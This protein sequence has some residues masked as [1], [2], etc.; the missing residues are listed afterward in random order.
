MENKY[1]ATHPEASSRNIIKNVNLCQDETKPDKNGKCT[2]CIAITIH[3]SSYTHERVTGINLWLTIQP[4]TSTCRPQQPGIGRPTLWWT[5]KD[6]FLF[7]R[8]S[9][10]STYTFRVHPIYR[11]ADMVDMGISCPICDNMNT[12]FRNYIAE[13]RCLWKC[14]M[15]TFRVKFIVSV[16]CCHFGR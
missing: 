12:L 16:Y 15:I 4:N 6:Q 10:L 13:K 8:P 3:T 1:M 11:L 9:F 2:V 5:T 14:I 7:H